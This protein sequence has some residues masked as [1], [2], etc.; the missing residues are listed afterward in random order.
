MISKDEL[1]EIMGGTTMDDDSWRE[2]LAECD[3]NGDGVVI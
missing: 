2:I 1:K 3:K